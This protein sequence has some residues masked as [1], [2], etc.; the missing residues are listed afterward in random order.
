MHVT[1][2]IHV[3]VEFLTNSSRLKSPA[4]CWSILVFLACICNIDFSVRHNRT[5]ENLHPGLEIAMSFV[6][7][8]WSSDSRHEAVLW[9]SFQKSFD[10][11]GPSSRLEKKQT[12]KSWKRHALF[13]SMLRY[14]RNRWE[15]KQ[16]IRNGIENEIRSIYN[17]K[18]FEIWT[19][20]M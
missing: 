8:V 16:V 9:W 11:G 19:F 6:S 12:I 10:T 5:F 1:F 2:P 17:D 14:E 4:Q 7:N 13:D 15:F 20:Y 18:Y 3:V